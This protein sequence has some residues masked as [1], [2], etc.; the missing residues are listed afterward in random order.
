MRKGVEVPTP[1]QASPQILAI[2]D[3]FQGKS[4]G[5]SNLKH[6]SKSMWLIAVTLN[7]FC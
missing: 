5:V 7:H 6:I 4:F 3:R 2:D 1:C